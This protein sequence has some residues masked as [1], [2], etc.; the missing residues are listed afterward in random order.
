MLTQVCSP[1][2]LKVCYNIY[3]KQF[4]QTISIYILQ[5]TETMFFFG[6]QIAEEF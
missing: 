2:Q 6:I 4:K 3:T 1:T 5:E